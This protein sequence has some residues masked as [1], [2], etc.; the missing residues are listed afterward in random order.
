MPSTLSTYRL[1]LTAAMA[2]V[3]IGVGSRTPTAQ[4]AKPQPTK[5]PVATPQAT[6]P[7]P[8]PKEP[9][10]A[11]FVERVNEYV[12]LHKKLEATLPKLP[13]KATPQQIDQNERELGNKIQA[14]RKNAKRGELFTPEMTVF[15]K[16]VMAQVF[17]G[18]EGQKLRSSIMD[19]NVK[20]MPLRVN[21]RFPDVIPISTMPPAILKALPEL[22]E[23]MQYRFVAS[24]FVL[25]DSHSHLVADFIPA[26]LPPIK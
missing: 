1:A 26:V 18:P 2:V 25:L 12:A 8:G 15:V 9:A 4:T 22:P 11:T 16:N 21:Q 7:Q 14:A 13:E 3:T 6:A 19:E 20:E 24:Q 10:V 5:T 23:Q 17:G